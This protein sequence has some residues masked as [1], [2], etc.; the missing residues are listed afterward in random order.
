MGSLIDWLFARFMPHGHC[1]FWTPDVLWM[2]VVSD[3]LI[4]L[5][6]Y[7]IPVTLLY[8]TR[9]RRDLPYPW[10]FYCFGAFIVAC[11][12]TH[13]ID[14]VTLWVPVYRVDGAV[15]AV[16]AALSVTTAVLLVP[17][18]PKALSLRGPAQ[19]E[20]ANERLDALNRS[21]AATSEEL[22]R[23]NTELEQFAYV[24]SHDLQEPLRVVSGCVQILKR[25]Y[26]DK[27]DADADE[28]IRHT[29]AGAAQMQALIVDLLAL[30]RVMTAAQPIEP[31]DASVVVRSALANLDAA[32]RE[33]DARVKVGTLPRVRGDRT[34]LVQLFQNLVANAIK[35]T[36]GRRPEIAVDAE[37]DGDG[38]WR[39]T[40]RDNGIGIEPQYFERIFRIFQRLHTRAEYAGTG[41]GL[42]ICQ[43]IVERH[44]GR[45]WVES[46]SGEGSS[47]HFTLQDC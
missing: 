30:S 7:S 37:K 16:T 41:I 29:V 2:H 27:L 44:G 45:I 42:A 39:F 10:V 14:I 31:I 21:L 3:A 28:L 43:K 6:Y 22:R 19:L 36:G 4:A 23:S 18:V 9:H 24:A 46:K 8:F 26:A 17:L 38:R 40:V 35:F 1:F 11:G 13:V 12:T 15:K 20:A 33:R 5:A 47:F 34:Q 25:R 32:I